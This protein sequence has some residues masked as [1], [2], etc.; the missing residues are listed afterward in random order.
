MS[1]IYGPHQ[2]GTE[3]QGWVAHFLIRAINGEPI[4][5]YGDGMQVRDVLFID[6][7]V[8]ALLLAEKHIGQIAGRAFNI[9]GGPA[10][11]T[12]LVELL[13]AIRELHGGKLEVRSELWRTG[14]QRY[15]VSDTRRF[16]AATGW[17]PR[18]G[19]RE[20]IVRLYDWLLQSRGLEP[21]GR[22]AG[23]VA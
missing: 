21:R 18:I 10:N 2:V 8:E 23:R 20:G 22:V 19:V 13:E 15:Y 7:L 6:D 5:V 12:S 17:S 4:T 16:R 14:D 1:C 11:T 3:D 9:G